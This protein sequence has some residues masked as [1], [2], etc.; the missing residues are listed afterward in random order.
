MASAV[1]AQA[2]LRTLIHV[3]AGHGTRRAVPRLAHA[4]VRALV[5]HTAPA[6]HTHAPPSQN[7]TCL[8]AKPKGLALEIQWSDTDL[9]QAGV[10]TLVHVGAVAGGGGSETGLASTFVTARGVAAATAAAHARGGSALVYVHTRVAG[11]RLIPRVA[12]AHE[13]ATEIYHLLG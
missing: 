11:R 9:A 4:H 6:L 5:V 13:T 12:L 7:V 3:H 8:L 10:G 2:Q 1:A